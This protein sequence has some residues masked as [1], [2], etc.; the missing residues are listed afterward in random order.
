M[1]F[2]SSILTGKRNSILQHKVQHHQSSGTL[3]LHETEIIQRIVQHDRDMA[4]CTQ[5]IQSSTA[6]SL[7]PPAAPPSPTPVI[8]TPLLQAPLQAAAATTPLALALAH[9]PQLPPIL[10]Q[11]PL[12]PGSGSV[13]DHSH[14]RRVHIG[15]NVSSSY[16]SVPSSPVGSVKPRSV[17]ETTTLGFSLPQ[18][19]S[20]GVL[21]STMMS[22][23][24]FTSSLQPLTS[25]SNPQPLYQPSNCGMTPVFPLSQATVSYT[26]SAQ[27]HPQPFLGAMTNPPQPLGLFQQGAPGKLVGRF[28]APGITPLICSSVSPILSQ[29]QQTCHPSSLNRVRSTS[30]NINLPHF[31]ITTRRQ[32][33]VGLNPPP[34]AGRRGVAASLAQH[35]LAGL[36][37]VFLPQVLPEHSALA[38]LAQYGSA[39]TSPCHTPPLRSPATLSPV[40]ARTVHHSELP[41]TTSFH[42]SLPLQSS[43]P[44]GASTLRE[45]AESSADLFTQEIE[46]ISGSHSY[47]HQ[48]RPSVVS[49]SSEG[50]TGGFHSPT[51][52]NKPYTPIPGQVVPVSR[53]Q[54]GPEPWNR[55]A[56]DQSPAKVS[57]SELKQSK[58]PSNL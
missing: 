19:L 42:G 22:Q 48:E 29:L 37:S 17:L 24:I 45:T 54:P 25:L 9:H 16:G 58:L 1:V 15:G 26:C 38:S 40:R 10:F 21:S 39:D 36:Q 4:Q 12:A 23:P 3:N 30:S 18:H 31:P 28:P 8:W 41:T 50:A 7:N 32:P 14:S 43:C 56:V 57:D 53:T 13:K 5:L 46:T 2:S 6:Q 27:L 35:T 34:S 51:A 11:S 49:G 44:R 52:V 33:P 47:L 55:P 20:S